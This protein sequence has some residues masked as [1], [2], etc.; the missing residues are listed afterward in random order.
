VLR[1]QEGG[2]EVTEILTGRGGKRDVAY[3]ACGMLLGVMAPIGWIILR[4]ILFW[5][6]SQSLSGQVMQDIIGTEQSRYMYTYMCGGT[7]V[8]LGLFGFFIGRASQQI[9]D[10]A[11]KL[12][13]LNREVAEQKAY[14]AQRFTALDRSIKNFHII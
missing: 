11:L 4:L 8:V 2:V 10:R 3:A 6:D 12:D 5:D 14:F 7:M 13:I 1:L 9:H